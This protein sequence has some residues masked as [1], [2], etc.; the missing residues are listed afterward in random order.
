M[1]TRTSRTYRLLD[2]D[3]VDLDALE[4]RGRA[5]LADLQKMARQG[6]SYFEVYRTALGPGS[7]AL[8]GRNRVDPELARAPLYRAALDVATRAGM[9][10][11]LILAPQ[12][13]GERAGA[14]T[15]GSMISAAQAADLIGMSRAAVYKAISTGRLRS[16]RIG[17]VTVVERRSAEEYREERSTNNHTAAARARHHQKAR[18]IQ[19]HA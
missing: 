6:V 15:D 16:R 4:A 8:A 9:R 7:P 19:A 13:E 14:S 2:G 5:F 1:A 11:G 17:N 10:Q 18:A 12:F 3:E